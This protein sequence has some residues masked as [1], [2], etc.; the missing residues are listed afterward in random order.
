MG[1]QWGGGGMINSWRTD[2]SNIWLAFLRSYFGPVN[3][4]A[5]EGRVVRKKEPE[6]LLPLK[7]LPPDLES[8]RDVWVG[9]AVQDGIGA[10]LVSV[11]ESPGQ[12]M[13]LWRGSCE[14][15][16]RRASVGN[17]CSRKHD[18]CERPR[19]TP[20]LRHHHG[21]HSLSV[22][23]AASS[24]GAGWTKAVGEEHGAC[25]ACVLLHTQ[26]HAHLT[27]MCSET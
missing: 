24:T 13:A 14:C 20:S 6:A 18:F 8:K 16:G 2:A 15:C 26:V 5:Q 7:R 25:A 19:P 17:P 21:H 27:H 23:C 11:E 12:P 3:A 1:W 9:E 4:D 22:T 10:P